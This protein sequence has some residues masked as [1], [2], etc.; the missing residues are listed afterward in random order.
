[1]YTVGSLHVCFGR[2][3]HDAP[4]DNDVMKT[5]SVLGIFFRHMALVPFLPMLELTKIQLERVFT[6][7]ENIV[8]SP[9]I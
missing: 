3:N 8:G 9:K 6:N 4:H 1:M 7:N 5:N 2:K